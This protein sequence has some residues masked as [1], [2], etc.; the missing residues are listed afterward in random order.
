[1][2]DLSFNGDSNESPLQNGLI[3]HTF[4]ADGAY[5]R[6][7][8]RALRADTAV[9]SAWCL[10]HGLTALPATPAT[11]AAFIDGMAVLRRSA[12]IRRYVSSIATLHRA[13]DLPN[14]TSAESVRL[15]LRR[16][17]RER[18]RRQDQAEGLTS[19]LRHRL[20]G[21]CVAS[22]RLIAQRDAALVALCYDAC[23]RRSELVALTV[24]DLSIAAD[25]SATVLVGRSKADPE[26]RG[27]TRF[28]APDTVSLISAWLTAAD[29][30][31]GL[32]IRSV[33]R[34]GRVGPA[35]EAGG[36]SRILKR[37]GRD[38]GLPADQV[39]RLSGHSPRVGVAQDMVAAG[40]ELPAIMQAGGWRSP[41]MV[42]RYTE[43]L[44][45]RRG[46]SARLAVAQGRY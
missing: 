30:N 15:A 22:P 4:A 20:I 10:E 35:L 3:N 26:G 45:V 32:L 28:L 19:D 7:T 16:L 8:E 9:F 17:H 44:A 40:V 12:T 6:H 24:A 37:L 33:D 41:E 29:I 46:G 31:Q 5:S 11:V 18:G 36:V 39:K 21:G 42:A 43:R 38:A 1:M 2:L 14:P 34:Y 23:L 25:G 27:S 13:A